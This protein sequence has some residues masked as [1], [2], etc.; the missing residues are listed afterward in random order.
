MH[1][2]SA[3]INWIVLINCINMTHDDS[4]NV[5]RLISL[6]IIVCR[7]ILVVK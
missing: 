2:L 7:V 4:L 3:I 5:Y 1:L 6:C